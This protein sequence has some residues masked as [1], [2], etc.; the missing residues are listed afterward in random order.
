MTT[1]HFEEEPGERS[2]IMKTKFS[3]KKENIYG[4]NDTIKKRKNQI[5]IY[6]VFLPNKKI[7]MVN[8]MQIR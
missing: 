6:L 7:V 5:K 4:K 3:S 8:M 2:N 1:Y